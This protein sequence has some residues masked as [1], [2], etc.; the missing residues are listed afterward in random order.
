VVLKGGRALDE[1]V[2]S[3]LLGRLID[4]AK[5]AAHAG[6]AAE[7]TEAVALLLGDESVVVAQAPFVCAGSQP[8]A[9]DA[10]VAKAWAKGEQEIAAAAVALSD[11]PAADMPPSHRTRCAL[12]A[13]SSDLP[14]VVKLRGRWIV[15]PLS[16]L[17]S[18]P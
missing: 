3:P 4:E 18:N 7:C 2:L 15:K 12:A 5:T 10:A 11:A 1:D 8:S 9:G 13:V 16:Q 17:P 6:A 14:L